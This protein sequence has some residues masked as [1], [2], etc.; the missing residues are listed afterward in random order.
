MAGQLLWI[1]LLPITHILAAHLLFCSYFNRQCFFFL[2]LTG[3]DVWLGNSRGSTYSQSHTTLPV[4]SQAYWSF[5]Y[6]EM[7]AVRAWWMCAFFSVC[8]GL[9]E[10]FVQ[11]HGTDK[12]TPVM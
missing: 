12:D 3:F 2:F 9:L 8:S 4:D 5:S 7:A 11:I 10:D 6:D 1:H